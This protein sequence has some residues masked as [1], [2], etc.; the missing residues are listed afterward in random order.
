ML[1]PFTGGCTSLESI[2]R[3]ETDATCL[4]EYRRLDNEL[5]GKSIETN[6]TSSAVIA[7]EPNPIIAG[8][9]FEVTLMNESDNELTTTGEDRYA[10]QRETGDGWFTIVGVPPDLEWDN[11]E[12]VLDSGEGFSWQLTATREEM[13][14]EPYVMCTL[15]NPETYRFVYWGLPEAE[16][17]P[18]V[19]FRIEENE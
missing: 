4:D 8:E 5:D 7:M 16:N 13:A 15:S 19:E 1:A 18:A 9:Q 6:P 14:E 10:I 2:R 12:T 11:R 3:G 17:L